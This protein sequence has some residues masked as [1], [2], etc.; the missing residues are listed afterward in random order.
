MGSPGLKSWQVGKL[1]AL[2][3]HVERALAAIAA[4]DLHLE[5]IIGRQ[6]ADQIAPVAEGKAYHQSVFINCPFDDDYKPLFQAMV[7][8]V[9]RCGYLP[10][11]AKEQDDSSGVDE[12]GEVRALSC[13]S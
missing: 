13:A 9:I 4:G 2:R 3:K 6:F 11:C 7:F 1:N 12:R 8:T 10:R 5:L